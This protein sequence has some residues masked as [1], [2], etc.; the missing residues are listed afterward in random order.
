MAEIS[1]KCPYSAQPI[2][3]SLLGTHLLPRH[4]P[5]PRHTPSG[6]SS[7]EQAHVFNQQESSS[8]ESLS[9]RPHPRL[10]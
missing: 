9:S 3:T 7:D 1:L 4:S 8:A 6:V 10:V 2:N 5:S